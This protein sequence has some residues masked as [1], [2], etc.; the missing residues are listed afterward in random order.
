MPERTPKQVSK[1]ILVIR[2]DKLGDFMLACPVKSLTY[3]YGVKL[4][5]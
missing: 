4:T 5:F 3:F 2:N 1:R